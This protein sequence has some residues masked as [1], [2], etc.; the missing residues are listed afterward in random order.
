MRN[1]AIHH[2]GVFLRRIGLVLLSALFLALGIT[3]PHAA[4]AADQPV[5]NWASSDQDDLGTLQVSASYTQAIT[6]LTA[7][8]LSPETGAEVA[9][10]DDFVLRSGTAENGVW[11]TRDTFKLDRL[12]N[13]PV[14][15]DATAADGSQ[16]TAASIG[17]LSYFAVSVFDPFTANRTTVTY[18]HRDV[19]VHGRLLSRSPGTRELTP[20][21]DVPVSLS[22]R[23][24]GRNGN[25]DD[26]FGSATLTTDA[27]GR[28]SYTG[29]LTGA[30]D[31]DALYDY[32]DRFPGHLRGSSATLRI[33]IKQAQVRV[34]AAADP[35]RVD[36][37]AQIT[38]SGQATWRSPSGWQPLAGAR[39]T[40][41]PYSSSQE[42]TTGS[43]GRYS[44]TLVPY[45][46]G[47]IPIYYTTQDPFVADALGSAS[48]IVVQPSVISEF[49][50][51]RGPD[52]GAINVRGN[53]FFTGLSAPADPQVDIQ[54]SPDGTT[55]HRKATLPANSFFSAT[56]PETRPGYWRARYRGGRYFQPSV[57]DVVYADPR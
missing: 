5:V 16:V 41:G 30:A 21:A 48:V 13:Y 42:V 22:Y 34:T 9:A 45:N 38:V 23:I 25:G 2:Q 15:V 49:E 17:Y 43:D 6:H 37:G 46:T 55:W 27:R 12:E 18:G 10:T 36:P 20:F 40:V 3:A 8:I 56:I 11:A 57:S 14:T 7:H 29:T 1:G 44:A 50:A 26:K 24:Y 53:L 35:R 28:F 51:E 39:L 31:F 47:D 19:V 32:Q 4:F 54:F 33:G 52:A